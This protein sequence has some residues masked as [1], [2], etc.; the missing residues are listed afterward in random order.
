MTYL[1]S[2]ARSLYFYLYAVLDIYSRKQ[3]AWEVHERENGEE[4]TML[5]ERACW[6]EQ[7]RDAPLTLHTDNDAAQTS[8]TLKSKLEALGISCSHSRPGVS[9]DNAHIEAWFRTLNMRPAIR[10]KA[11]RASSWREPGH[12]NLY[13][14]TTGL[15]CIVRWLI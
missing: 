3:A 1:H 11:L 12:L 13:P 2:R 7:R 15:I 5:I 6:R 14:G 9:D 10:P 4:A 8:Y